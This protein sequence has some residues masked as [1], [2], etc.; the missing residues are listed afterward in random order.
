MVPNFSSTWAAA[1]STVNTTIINSERRF[2][3]VVE[4][5]T[6]TPFRITESGGRGVAILGTV[7]SEALSC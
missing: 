6:E 1:D 2:C 5:V 3:S 4:G 7:V